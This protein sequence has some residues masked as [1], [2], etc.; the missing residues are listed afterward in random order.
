MSNTQGIEIDLS[1]FER[2]LL[3]HL[4]IKSCEE[5]VSVN[6]IITNLL[7]QY[8]KQNETRDI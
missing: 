4:I 5:D 8:L 3:E 1:I 7:E 2:E 6:K